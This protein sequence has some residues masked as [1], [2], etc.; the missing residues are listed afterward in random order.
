MEELGRLEKREKMVHYTTYIPIA[1]NQ[2]VFLYVLN[3]KSLLV[4]DGKV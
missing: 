4:F 2:A 3:S 1:G